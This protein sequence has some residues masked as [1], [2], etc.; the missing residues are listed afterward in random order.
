MYRYY[1]FLA[2]R[3][4]RKQP[5][6]A[7]LIVL[8]LGAGTGLFMTTWSLHSVLS[9]DPIPAKSERL[10]SLR[11][12][13]TFEDGE[14]VDL[15]SVPTVTVL[16]TA[17]Q[18]MVVVATASGYAI[19]ESSD[20][21][22]RK[23]HL[24]R[25]SDP[26][27]FQTFDVPFLEGRGWSRE[28]ESS[29]MPVA[30]IGRETAMA[31][32]DGTAVSGRS[33][34]VG[35][36]LFRVIGVLDDWSPSPRYYDIAAGTYTPAEQVFLPLSAI[37]RVDD[38]VQMTRM[39]PH[40]TEDGTSS[41]QTSSCAWLS[42]WVLVKDPVQRAVV[43]EN[44]QDALVQWRAREGVPDSLSAAKAESVRELLARKRVVPAGAWFG[45]LLASGFLLLCLV[46]A[47]GL[48]FAKCLQRTQEIGVRRSLGASRHDILRQ[49][50]VEAA[51]LGVASSIAGV[52]I[53]AI[54]TQITRLLPQHYMQLA[55][56]SWT[57]LALTVVLSFLIGIAAGLLPAWRASQIDPAIQMKVE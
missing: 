43:E 51:L 20:G 22:R 19:I 21:A 6:L 36:A 56:F 42:A 44:L 3:S 48:L 37:A 29:H 41:M 38:S 47:A 31:L 12:G 52:V 10:L 4:F 50:M 57:V 26:E 30:V 39:C 45:I 40:G 1:V 16:R 11:F 28:E 8:V 23:S 53:A 35:G 49:F 2:I 24:I 18:G 5:G 46:N 32:F 55:S 33:I 54:G 25:F 27:F 7:L 34:V 13:G 14:P 17:L 9:G 15:M